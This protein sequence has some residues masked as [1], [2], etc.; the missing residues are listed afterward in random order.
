MRF[1]PVIVQH[2]GREFVGR[3]RAGVRDEP[4]HRLRLGFL[5]NTS[6]PEGGDG[7]SLRTVRRAV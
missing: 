6:A 1:V 4:C 7:E 2:L 3:D 5:Y